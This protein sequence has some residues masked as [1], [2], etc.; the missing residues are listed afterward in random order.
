MKKM[1]AQMEIRSLDI[2]PDFNEEEG[3]VRGHPILFNTR[4]SDLGGF[5]EIIDP[6]ALADVDMSDVALLYDHQSGNI[7]ARASAGT[8]KLEV[9]SEGVSFVATLPKTTVGNDVRENLRNGNLRGMSFGF[10]VA[11]REWLNRDG[12]IPTQRI[13]RIGKLFEISLTAF[14]AY[15][16]T[17]VALSQRSL[18]QF[19]NQELELQT[20][21]EWFAI[22]KLRH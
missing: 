14:P 10:T 3:V 5:D 8:L 16:Q 11:E 13:K 20:Q 6:D 18:D 1:T 7:L 17:D 4:S 21:K 12:Q 22:Q 19:R 2:E 9:G 15:K